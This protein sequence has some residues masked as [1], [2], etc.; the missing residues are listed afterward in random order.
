MTKHVYQYIKGLKL[1]GKTLD[2]GALDVNGCVRDL[3]DDYTGVDM[4]EGPN[5]DEVMN[6]HVLMWPACTF[7]NVLCLETLEHD[8][9]FWLTVSEMKRVLKRG[10]RLVITVPGIGFPKHDYP[11]DFWRFTADALESMLDDMSRVD[12][13]E[14]RGTRGA[15]YAHGVKF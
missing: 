4:R 15:V 2:I 10:G 1:K 6:S 14:P 9:C 12:V 3:F 11:N 13:D 8:D 5:V 7:D